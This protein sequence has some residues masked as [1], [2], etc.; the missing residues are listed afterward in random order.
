MNKRAKLNNVDARGDQAVD[1][2]HL[3]IDWDDLRFHL[4]AVPQCHVVNVQVIHFSVS[5]MSRTSKYMPMHPDGQWPVTAGR[6]II[7]VCN[8]LNHREH[9]DTK[10]RAPAGP[11]LSL[12]SLVLSV[13]SV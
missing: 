11:R 1:P 8:S 2:C 5:R 10:R 4:Q 12:C 13:F 7:D 9:G 3:L 6:R